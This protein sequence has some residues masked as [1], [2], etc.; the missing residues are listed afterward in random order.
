MFLHHCVFSVYLMSF[1]L[2]EGNLGIGGS[3]L[4]KISSFLESNKSKSSG[5]ELKAEQFKDDLCSSKPHPQQLHLHE[6][7]SCGRVEAVAQHFLQKSVNCSHVSML[8]SM[9]SLK[10]VKLS[11][12]VAPLVCR[13]LQSA[14]L[15]QLNLTN[16][17]LGGDA[18]EAM[19]PLATSSR[20][21]HL[22][23]G[24]NAWS[25]QQLS[26]RPVLRGGRGGRGG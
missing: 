17:G 2:Q 7:L 3:T 21:T 16:C 10:N 24:G 5:S 4:R 20:L 25:M 12:D 15:Q 13:A 9:L 11:R 8:V 19:V 26:C 22:L 18:A 6:L 1:Y 23:V 14:V